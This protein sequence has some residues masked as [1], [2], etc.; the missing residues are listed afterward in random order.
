M[1]ASALLIV[2]VLL[3]CSLG[4]RGGRDEAV[5]DTKVAAAV[6]AVQAKAKAG[7][8]TC[9]ATVDRLVALSMIDAEAS[10]QAWSAA[11]RVQKHKMYLDRCTK[12]LAEGVVTRDAMLCVEGSKDL[13]A[14]RECLLAIAK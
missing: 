12:E 5:A 2:T 14:A 9:E 11:Q 1:R 13:G 7:E 10:G 4:E 8:G 6:P 3:A